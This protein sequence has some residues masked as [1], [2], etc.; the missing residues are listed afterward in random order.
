MNRNCHPLLKPLIS[1]VKVL[2][3]TLGRDY[4]ILLHDVSGKVP[5]TVAAENAELTGRDIDTPLTDFGYFLV[6]DKET[7]E[8]DHIANYRSQTPD[9]R[10]LRSSV[11]M[12]R[13]EEKK[14]IGLLCINYDTTKATMLKDMGEFLTSFRPAP[15]PGIEKF[16]PSHVDQPEELIV[17]ARQ[18]LGKPL[19]YATCEE[20]RRTIS[21][22]DE[23][24]FFRLKKAMSKL[25]EIAGKS[26]YTLYADLRTVRAQKKSGTK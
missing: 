17:K 5:F 22:L 26:R 21:W 1:V 24:G 15:G 11:A 9:G 23:K 4:E 25:T 14:I 16:T 20:R 10:T 19:R 6:E 8:M 3:E 2:G 7:H 18:L 13:D 12:I